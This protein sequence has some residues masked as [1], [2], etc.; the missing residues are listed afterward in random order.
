MEGKQHSA[1][2]QGTVQPTRD[3]FAGPVITIIK[4]L[5]K[6]DEDAAPYNF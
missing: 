3:G 4:L 6:E 2:A 1:G 5:P